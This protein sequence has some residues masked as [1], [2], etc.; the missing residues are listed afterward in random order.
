[1]NPVLRV[2]DLGFSFGGLRAIERISLSA[3]RGEVVG[4]IG[5]NGSGKSTFFDLLCGFRIPQDGRI[6]LQEEDVTRLTVEARARRGLGRTFQ[7]PVAFHGLTVEEHLRVA[8]LAKGVR[9][10]DRARDAEGAAQDLLDVTTIS[11][12]RQELVEKLSVEE[13]RILDLARAVSQSPAVLLLDEPLAGLDSGQV[14]AV[15]SCIRRV[16][17]LEASILIVEHRL[18]AL[19]SLVTRVALFHQGSLLATGTPEEILHDDKLLPAYGGS[20]VEPESP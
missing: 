15:V 5:P 17:A 7:R 1:M 4:I 20:L 9:D 12:R 14:A 3:H 10:P 16:R 11:E 8:R 6:W 2:E 19:L 13:G 18:E